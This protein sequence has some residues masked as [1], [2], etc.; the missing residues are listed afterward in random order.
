MTDPVRKAFTVAVAPARAWAAFADPV[1]RSRWEAETYEIDPRPGGRVH[2]ELPGIECSGVVD[3]VERE[4]LLRHTESDGP[5][6]GSVITRGWCATG[7]TGGRLP[8]ASTAW[9]A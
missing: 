8:R 1:E 7:E 5:H 6:H 9:S 3:E 2:W 4:R